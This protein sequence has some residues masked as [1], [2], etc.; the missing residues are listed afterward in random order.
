MR[1]RSPSTA[2]RR[3]PTADCWAQLNIDAKNFGGRIYSSGGARVFLR[4]Q[5]NAFAVCFDENANGSPRRQSDA[6]VGHGP[7]RILVPRNGTHPQSDRA[8]PQE[9]ARNR[10]RGLELGGKI[11]HRDYAADPFVASASIHRTEAG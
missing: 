11:R 4:N 7:V 9:C 5:S 1:A 2:G 3:S 10:S 6:F 8:P